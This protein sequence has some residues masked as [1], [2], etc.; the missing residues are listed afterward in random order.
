MK[1]ILLLTLMLAVAFAD[2][3]VSISQSGADPG[4]VM[5]GVKF[6][7]T[8]S[9]WSG[10]C[11]SATIDLGE[12]PVCS[13]QNEDTVKSITGSSISW[14]SVIASQTASNQKI[15]ISVSGCTPQS[16]ESSS[17]EVVLPPEL[18]VSYSPSSFSDPS[19]TEEISLTVENI[20]GTTAKDVIATLSLPSGI[21]TSE[22]LSKDLGS[23]SAEA[24]AG[25]SWLVSFTSPSTS[26][27]SISVTSSNAGSVEKTI[28]VTVSSSSQENEEGGGVGGGSVGGFA[29]PSSGNETETG[30]NESVGSGAEVRRALRITGEE[31]VME[32]QAQTFIN[33]IKIRKEGGGVVEVRFRKVEEKPDFLPDPPVRTLEFMEIEANESV[34]SAEIYFSIP[35]EELEA[36]GVGKDAV[37]L[38]RYHDGWQELPTEYLGMEN[39]AYSFRATSSG[40]SYFAVG[41]KENVPETPQVEQETSVQSNA[42]PAANGTVP[43]HGV[44]GG[45]KII[46]LLVLVAA[47]VLYYVFRLKK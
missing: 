45:F 34:D 37:V 22:S 15:S 31:A 6:T 33:R 41:Y 8:A 36:L 17:F 9:G 29:A 18:R 7:V 27:I 11:T 39:G 2:M 26:T 28:P 14:T 35:V 42:T 30:A 43:S 5:K 44:S 46:A 12:C 40:F 24:S 20:G 25:T 16:A 13:L 10:S 1:K 47:L 23:I 38:M 19:G 4:T 21:T 32:V 3:S